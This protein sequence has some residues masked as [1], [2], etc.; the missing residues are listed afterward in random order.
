MYRS[1]MQHMFV[2]S[3]IFLQS[4][5]MDIS[6]QYRTTEEFK[7]VLR[8]LQ[9]S[10]S[11]S[12]NIFWQSKGSHKTV[13]PIDH[14][15]ID[16]VTRGVVVFYKGHLQQLDP[17][18]PLFVK[19]DYKTSVFKVL[20]YSIQK[21]SIHFSIPS[22]IKTRELRSGPR[23][24][25]PMDLEKNVV[26]RPA[27]MSDHSHVQ[28]TSAKVIDLSLRGLGLAISQNAYQFFKKNRILWVTHI[29]DLRLEVPLLSEVRY[30]NDDLDAHFQKS[31]NK[32]LKVGL[33]LS[34]TIP[35]ETLIS[36][37]EMS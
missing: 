28:E 29:D 32:Y 25:I 15:E 36:L 2:N 20:E 11:L 30:I 8:T 26:L 1:G 3:I 35:K 24:I 5:S 17:A 4:I 27:V 6:K 23:H 9:R 18:L 34:S 16:F 37:I 33:H 7:E 12:D 19:L 13:F 14:F 10:T 21:D 31:K 22:L